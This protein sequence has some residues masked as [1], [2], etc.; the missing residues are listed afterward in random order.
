MLS[1]ADSA[2]GRPTSDW[3]W[4]IWRCRFELVNHVEVDDA[5]RADPGRSQ[6]QQGG[7]A[8]P[9]GPDDQDLGVLQPLLPG[10]AH[11]GDD[12]VTGV[13]PDLVDGQC[14][15]GLHQRG[16]RHDA[17]L[18]HMGLRHDQPAGAKR[19]FPHALRRRVEHD[20]HLGGDLGGVFHV[21]QVAGARQDHDPCIGE[22]VRGPARHAR[23]DH[24]VVA[25]VDDQGGRGDA[26]RVA[27]GRVAA[28]AEELGGQGPDRADQ[29]GGG[30]VE[31]V[32]L[33]E[34]GDLGGEAC[35]AGSSAGSLKQ[36]AD[37]VGDAVLRRQGVVLAQQA[38]ADPRAG[39]SPAN[40]TWSR[41]GRES[42]R[43]GEIRVRVLTSSGRVAASL[44]ATAP[45]REL[46]IRWTGAVVCAVR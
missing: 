20:R 10:H 8:R 1:R 39:S 45:P 26:G 12:Q 21:G 7:R 43:A 5:E 32:A 42:G 29:G 15:G 2:F 31:G 24:A 13:T 46:A 33:G 27:P 17:L 36:L 14:F 16:Q 22:G 28:L 9:P 37:D 6:V 3:P 4:M 30:V 11:V 40:C 19:E 18:V 25:A 34:F 44:T 35:L 38:V 41:R 23:V